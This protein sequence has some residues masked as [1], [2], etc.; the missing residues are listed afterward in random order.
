MYSYMSILYVDGEVLHGSNVT[1][2]LLL[3]STVVYFLSKK[4][5]LCI[6]VLPVNFLNLTL[7]AII[8]D[9]VCLLA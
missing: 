6:V 7:V 8:Y 5:N 2:Q 4:L 1:F 9:S 3:F